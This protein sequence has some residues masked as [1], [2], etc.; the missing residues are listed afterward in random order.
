MYKF[1]DLKFFVIISSS[2][3]LVM[4]QAS[5]RWLWIAKLILRKL[6]SLVGEF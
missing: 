1:F 2:R 6:K 4:L 3:G 5:W